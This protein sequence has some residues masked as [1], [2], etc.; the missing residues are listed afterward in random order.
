MK[1]LLINGIGKLA[2]IFLLAT[3]SCNESYLELEPVGSLNESVLANRAGVDGLLIGAYS[4][5]D[6]VGANGSGNPWQSP[7]SNY[8]LGG[9]ASDDSHKGTEYGD[10]S[11]ME[12]IENYTHTPITTSFNSKWVALYAGV[13]RANDVLRILERVKPGAISEQERVQISSEAIFL[14][15]VYHFE[16]AKVWRN[17]PY[18]DEK[19]TFSGNN[20]LISNTTPIWPMI[21]KDLLQSISTLTPTKSDAARANSW[22]AK[23]ILAKVYMFQH[24]YIDAQKLLTDIIANGI[25]ASGKKYALTKRLLYPSIFIK[26]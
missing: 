15:A 1:N 26:C 21:E 11:Y 22:A 3:M 9:I 19:I 23:A 14:R 6:G 8:L 10:E 2:L 7:V 24:K 20:Y 18:V 12:Q 5:L 13:Q 4:L 17:V 16:A 25:T